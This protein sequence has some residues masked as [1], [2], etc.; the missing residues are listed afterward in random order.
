MN[1]KTCGCSLGKCIDCHLFDLNKIQVGIDRY[2]REKFID[3]DETKK[4]FYNF[5][6]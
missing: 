5:F 3:Q 1:T 6:K 4:P 2:F